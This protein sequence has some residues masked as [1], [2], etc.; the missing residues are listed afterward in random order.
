MTFTEP[1]KPNALGGPDGF[2]KLVTDPNTDELLGA[3]AVGEQCAEIVHELVLAIE[4]GAT[5]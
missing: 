3:H 4:L 5:A 2:V 1:S